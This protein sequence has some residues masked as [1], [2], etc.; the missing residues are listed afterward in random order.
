[1][2]DPT[3][4]KDRYAALYDRTFRVLFDAGITELRA[5]ELATHR[6]LAVAA[7]SCERPFRFPAP[8]RITLDDFQ[9]EAERECA[10][11]RQFDLY[12]LRCTRDP[13]R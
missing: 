4:S 3:G 11:L 7:M 10:A 2:H 9:N 5:D 6:T 13:Q 1:M 12:T 8:E